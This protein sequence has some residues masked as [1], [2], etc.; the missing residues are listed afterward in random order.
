VDEAGRCVEV[1]IDGGVGVLRNRI[2]AE[3]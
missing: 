3:A 2:I 1:E